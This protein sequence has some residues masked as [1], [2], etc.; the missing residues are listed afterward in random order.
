MVLLPA[1]V[2]LGVTESAE[3]SFPSPIKLFVNNLSQLTSQFAF[4]EPINIAD[5]QI[6]VNAFCGTVTLI[7]AVLYLLDK[8][9]KLR[10]RIAK[11]ALLVLLYASFDVNVLNYIWHG[12]HVQNGL[13]NRFAFIYIFLMLTMAFDAW[14]HMHPQLH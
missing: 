10:E 4:C 3:N 7:L 5:D 13:P 9:I 8:N 14:R 6:G 12:F 11:T 1:Y 2:A